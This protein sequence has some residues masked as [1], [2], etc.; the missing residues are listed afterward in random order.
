MSKISRVLFL[1]SKQLGLRVLQEMYSLSPTTL[2]GALTIDD[3]DDTRTKFAAFHALAQTHGIELRVGNNRKHAEEIILEMKPDFCLVAG[4]YWLITPAT[5]KT[6]PLGFIGIH[7]SLLPKFRGGSPLIWAIINGEPEVGFSFFSFTPGMDDGPIWAQGTIAV[8]ESDY[9]S[10]VLQRLENKAIDVLRKIYP[11]LLNRSIKP[12]EQN[13]ELATYCV[14]RFPRDGDI[15]WHKPARAVYN[16]IRAQSDPYPGAFTYLEGQKL[17]IWKATL[18]P[19][20]CL[21]VPGQVVRIASEGVY[22]VCGDDRALI[23]EEV[24]LGRKR[25]K[26]NDLIRSVKGRMS[27]FTTEK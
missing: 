3:S 1:G 23:L 6:V 25:G 27:N 13:N 10:S 7:T 9:I 24:E 4:W 18:S 20:R 8:E 16:F 17:T 22:V 5:L 26:A 19:E 21:G 14:R 15:N 11:E 2:I 12:V